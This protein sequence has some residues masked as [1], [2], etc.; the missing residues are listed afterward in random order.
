MYKSARYYFRK[1]PVNKT[2]PKQ[3]RKYIPM[4]REILDIMDEHITNGLRNNN[5][6]PSD[7]YNQFIV[8]NKELMGRAIQK[9]V[10]DGFIDSKAITTKIKKTYKNRYFQIIKS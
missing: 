3:R 1:K 10:S 5:Y 6:K 7:G 8:E 9:M 2:E 4:D